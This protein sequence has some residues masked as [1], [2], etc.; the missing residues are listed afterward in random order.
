MKW[1]KIVLLLIPVLSFG[2]RDVATVECTVKSL[3][4]TCLES[5]KLISELRYKVRHSDYGG[6]KI[7]K[8]YGRFEDLKTGL[9]DR[10]FYRNNIVL[11]CE[12]LLYDRQNGIYYALQ[13][14][15]KRTFYFL[16]I[17]DKL[18]YKGTENLNQIKSVNTEAEAKYLLL[19]SRSHEHE[20]DYEAQY[21]YYHPDGTLAYSFHQ[22]ADEFDEFT[23]EYERNSEDHTVYKNGRLWKE[24]SSYREDDIIAYTV[25]EYVLT[26]SYQLDKKN[27]PYLK[28]S[29]FI[30]KNRN[31]SCEEGYVTKTE[32]W[33]DNK[34]MPP[35]ILE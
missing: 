25:T 13:N 35:V 18:R 23:Y 10:D 28:G 26:E 17:S 34:C 11:P 19:Y 12:Q 32:I 9:S 7:D 3:K 6:A 31:C 2:Q 30:T 16:Y 29:K 1:K 27:R 4:T 21:H 22:R 15:D 24:Y 8:V 14:D 5:S 20:E 33:A